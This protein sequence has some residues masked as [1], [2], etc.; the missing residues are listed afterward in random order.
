MQC[1]QSNKCFC[2]ECIVPYMNLVNICDHVK[3]YITDKLQKYREK[4]P[5]KLKLYF[6]KNHKIRCYD[7]KIIDILREI[8]QQKAEAVTRE[9]NQ[10]N[11]R[12]Q[13]ILENLRRSGFTGETTASLEQSS[14]VRV[15]SSL[16]LFSQNLRP[17][18]VTI[19]DQKTE[20]LSI[21]CIIC[22]E[23][24]KCALF[25]PCKHVTCCNS[26]SQRLLETTDKCPQCRGK[27]LK[28]ENIYL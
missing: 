14:D 1:L 2:Y 26:C 8:Q 13:I 24:K 15:I 7:K 28:I 17:N 20:E 3:T 19:E 9:I 16:I 6:F 25:S 22:R 12:N 11:Q 4:R 5:N 10:I 23:N 18:I 27:I 21:Q